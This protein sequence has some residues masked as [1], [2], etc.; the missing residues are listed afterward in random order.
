MSAERESVCACVWC[1]CV[2]MC[3]SPQLLFNRNTHTHTFSSLI[4]HTLSHLAP[5]PPCLSYT[6]THT[7]HHTHQPHT[8]TRHTPTHT[9]PQHTTRQSYRISNSNDWVFTAGDKPE[10]PDPLPSPPSLI[11]HS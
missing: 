1:V 5:T 2:C 7:H 4:S 8:T 10:S 6:H 9:T 11:S 3:L